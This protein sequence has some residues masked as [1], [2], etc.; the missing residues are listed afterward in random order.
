MSLE[1]RLHYLIILVLKGMVERRAQKMP[2]DSFLLTPKG[3][4]L[5]TPSARSRQLTDSSPS[6][7]IVSD[8]LNGPRSSLRIEDCTCSV[9]QSYSS[10][11]HSTRVSLKR[12]VCTSPTLPTNT[13]C[14]YMAG[15]FSSVD[16]GKKNVPDYKICA[17]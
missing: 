11:K 1:I 15:N 13:H 12:D 7:H 4:H 9:Y 10:S 2:V 14:T 16:G 5:R 3:S 6:A 8:D 17:T